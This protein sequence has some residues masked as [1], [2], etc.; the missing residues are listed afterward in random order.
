M[1]GICLWNTPIERTYPSPSTRINHRL[2]LGRFPL[3]GIGTSIRNAIRHWYYCM[4]FYG[5]HLHQLAL[6]LFQLALYATASNPRLL[7]GAPLGLHLLDS[8]SHIGQAPYLFDPH[9]PTQRNGGVYM[10]IPSSNPPDADPSNAA[11][12]VAAMPP[13]IGL[14]SHRTPMRY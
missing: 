11:D 14:G 5:F 8:C 9:P 7:R 13:N 3:A 2:V 4:V 6:C 1:L 10:I 12:Q